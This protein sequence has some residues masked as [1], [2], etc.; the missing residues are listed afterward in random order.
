MGLKRI[1]TFSKIKTKRKGRR[2]GKRI[3]IRFE[4]EGDGIRESWKNSRSGGTFEF[5]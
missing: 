5:A 1:D 3:F 4:A 2:C